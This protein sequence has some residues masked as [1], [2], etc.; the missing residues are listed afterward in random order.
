MPA[1]LNQLTQLISNKAMW[2][3][4]HTMSLAFQLHQTSLR[5]SPHT[6]L[7]QNALASSQCECLQHEDVFDMRP[8]DTQ[9]PAQHATW[10]LPAHLHPWPCHK[11]MLIAMWCTMPKRHRSCACIFKM[12]GVLDGSMQILTYLCKT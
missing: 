12:I 4:A 1:A 8:K 5:T 11:H 10:G 2:T 9:L 7:A 3:A 6:R